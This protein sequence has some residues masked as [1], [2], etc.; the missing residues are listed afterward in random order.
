LKYAR[1]GCVGGHIN[2]CVGGGASSLRMTYQSD[3]LRAYLLRLGGGFRRAL[4]RGSGFGQFCGCAPDTLSNR[5]RATR[6]EIEAV[7]DA[8]TTVQSSRE[9]ASL[10]PALQSWVKHGRA[11]S[12]CN[13]SS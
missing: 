13:A 11:D 8:R 4:R 12:H 7:C 3:L 6:I 9:K 5:H 10:H 2:I 1:P